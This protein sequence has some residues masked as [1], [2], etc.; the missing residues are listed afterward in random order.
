MWYLIRYQEKYSIFGHFWYFLF[1]EEAGGIIVSAGGQ[2]GGYPPT[3]SGNVFLVEANWHMFPLTTPAHIFT[4]TPTETHIYCA[5]DHGGNVWITK[6]KYHV[7]K[8]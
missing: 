8:N 3:G 7:Q 5:P 6:K 1:R 2:W 4:H